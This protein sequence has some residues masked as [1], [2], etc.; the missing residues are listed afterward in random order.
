MPRIIAGDVH[1]MVIDRFISDGN[2]GDIVADVSAGDLL[3]VVSVQQLSGMPRTRLE[4]IWSVSKIDGR[5]PVHEAV[6]LEVLV[7]TGQAVG[8]HG[9]VPCFQ[10]RP[11]IRVRDCR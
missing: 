5:C 2:I 6:A 8:Q 11:F 1:E 7:V 3:L 10:T 9:F 4:R